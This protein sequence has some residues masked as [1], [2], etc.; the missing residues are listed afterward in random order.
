MAKLTI[1]G[2]CLARQMPSFLNADLPDIL[3]FTDFR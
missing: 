2:R 3:I 1:S